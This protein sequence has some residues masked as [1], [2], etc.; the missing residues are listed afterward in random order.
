M[1]QE[2]QDHMNKKMSEEIKHKK[3][4]WVEFMQKEMKV[5][6]ELKNK[7]SPTRNYKALYNL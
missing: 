2:T 7:S 3:E 4:E 6:E 5:I 1:T